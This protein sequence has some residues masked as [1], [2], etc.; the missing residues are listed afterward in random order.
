[1]TDGRK[2]DETLGLKSLEARMGP[3]RRN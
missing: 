2:P 3:S 1:M